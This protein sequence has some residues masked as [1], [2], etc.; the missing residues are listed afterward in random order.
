MT[1]TTRIARWLAILSFAFG[2]L[3]IGYAMGRWSRA[4]EVAQATP[5]PG[6]STGTQTPTVSPSPTGTETPIPT[7][8]PVPP[9]T[10]EP[11]TA[12]PEIW[13]DPLAQPGLSKVGL[14]VVRNN[15][16][17]VM[18]FVRRMQPPVMKAV[19]DT[20][21]L[22]DVKQ[23]SPTTVTIGR[24]NSQE[25]TVV[26]NADPAAYA[27]QYVDAHLEKYRL[28]P[29]ADYWEGWNEYDPPDPGAWQWYA[30]FEAERACYMAAQGLKAAIGGFSTGVPEYD[31]M[32]MFLPALQA[33]QRCGAILSLHE[34][35]A[36]TMQCG[37]PGGIPGAPIFPDVEVGITT[38]R[39]RFWYEGY[40]KPLGLSDVRLVIS[41][42]GI[43]GGAQFCQG[44]NGAGW[45]DYRNW[46]LASGMT[47][48]SIGF[49]L[50]QIKWYDSQV[51]KDPYV[52][53]FTLFTAGTRGYADGIG[54][55]EI[56]EMIIPLAFYMSSVASSQ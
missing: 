32:G 48:D 3:L 25:F 5:L 38:L 56:H 19:D 2:L 51:R 36:P 28:N 4:R 35:A 46:W 18:E 45:N 54:S 42:T 30:A 8:T 20:G 50:D 23:A 21:W 40:L 34:Y 27:R 44:A 22:T 49:Y 17:H 53:G 9:P 15:D 10:A 14:H 41:E 52:I 24:F 31:E 26:G 43:D 1:S 39:Y 13:P 55:W 12:V 33:A 11:P 47:T 37:V 6:T 7:E 29:G 16:P